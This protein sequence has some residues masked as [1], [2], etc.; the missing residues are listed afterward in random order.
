MRDGLVCAV[1]PRYTTCVV[2]GAGGVVV[3]R[4]GDSGAV[5]EAGPPE[6]Q[7]LRFSSLAPGRLFD[8]RYRIEATLG[9][10]GSGEVFRA[11]DERTGLDVALKV[12]FPG[13]ALSR[14]DRLARE[15]AI[16]RSLRHEGV[17]RVD[18]VGEHD[19]LLYLVSEHLEGE[20]LYQ[21]LARDGASARSRV[22]EI[23]VKLLEGL[24][25]IHEA[26][27][28]HRDVKPSNI[29]LTTDG[30]VVLLDLGLA[31]SSRSPRLT[32]V[33]R[34]LGTPEY[35]A[36]EQ[37]RGEGE[38]TA[39]ADLYA[40]GA[41]M[42]ELLVG[43]PP[44]TGSAGEVLEAQL[45]RALPR[46]PDAFRRC[47]RRTRFLLRAC[48]EKDARRRPRDAREALRWLEGG[49]PIAARAARLWPF[50]VRWPGL[51]LVFTA[52]VLAIAGLWWLAP[53][54]PLPSERGVAWEGAAGAPF[55]TELAERP[56]F[57]ARG[58]SLA[59]RWPAA[60]AVTEPAGVGGP[61]LWHL[62]SPFAAPRAVE[63]SWRDELDRVRYPGVADPHR[64]R[65]LVSLADVRRAGEAELALLTHRTPHYP[66]AVTLVDRAGQGVSFHHPGHLLGDIETF[67]QGGDG[68]LFLLLRGVNN[69]LGPRPVI[70]A[71]PADHR[72]HGQALPFAA[73]VQAAP[74]GGG[75]TYVL[76]RFRDY[77]DVGVALVSDGTIRVDIP[78]DQHFFLYADDGVPVSAER[79][80]GLAREAWRDAR[81]ALYE[82]LFHAA[83]LSQVGEHGDGAARLESWAGEANAPEALRGLAFHCAATMR[84]RTAYEGGAAAARATLDAARRARRLAGATPRGL[85]L[86]AEVLARLGEKGALEAVF[87]RRE[88]IQQQP[89]AILSWYHV[90]QRAGG[91]VSNERLE[92]QWPSDQ[93]QLRSKWGLLFALVRAHDAGE[94]QRVRA[95]LRETTLDSLWA[96]HHY[97]ASRAAHALGLSEEAWTQLRAAQAA[98]RVGGDVPL[99]C[100]ECRLSRAAGQGPEA[101]IR[102]AAL[103]EIAS[104]GRRE[105]L[106]A[107]AHA[108]LALARGDAGLSGR[109]AARDEAAQAYR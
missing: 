9:A 70:V 61:R 18:D 92:A 79:R 87:D 23:L 36:P 67:R 30:R 94:H 78:P 27:V 102:D 17:L 60:W 74:R 41:S 105:A 97:W 19:G 48:L 99:A 21:L 64:V 14:P 65:A 24:A 107:T 8:G 46:A 109:D 95:L 66:A 96:A 88:G 98:P 106:D 71:L 49:S 81:E 37:I 69:L 108:H 77:R 6:N 51:A 26:G 42:W 50:R 4:D 33:G 59:G 28:V 45:R 55:E 73:P 20:P 54:A 104:L 7:I 80:G 43:Q 35:A 56:V 13:G 2:S 40:L 52:A 47:R 22:E 53:R 29:F 86:E 25:A 58:R 62:A 16:S 83:G 68:R 91:V 3:E 100:L 39:S 76:P 63:G 10:G 89:D 93:A 75:W 12:I 32:S 57:V 72:A 90:N 101:E 85:L 15:L 31:C 84:A 34:F 1:S 11:R 103:E 38:P 44:F 5:T 82:A